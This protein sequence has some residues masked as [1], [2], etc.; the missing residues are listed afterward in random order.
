M[1]RLSGLD[2]SFLYLETPAQLHARV[3]PDRARPGARSPDG[4][5]FATMRAEIDAP[6]RATSRSSAASCARSRCGLDHPVWVDDDALRH[7][8]A[9]APAR[10][11]RRPAGTSELADLCGHLAGIPLDRSRPLWEMWVI[12]GLDDGRGRG[13]H[14]DAPRHRRRRLRREPDLPP[15]QPRARRRRRSAPARAGAARPRRPASASCSAARWCATCAQPV[16]A[17]RLL[18]PSVQRWSPAPSTA[19]AA[20]R[21][22]AAPFTAPRTSFNGTITGHRAIA[23][24]RPGPR[25]RSRR[26]RTPPART[27]NDVVLTVSRRRA[28]RATSSDRGELP[29]TSLLATVPVSVRGSR[30]ARAAPTRSRRSSPGSAPTSR[31]RSSG[32][33]TSAEQQPQR[34][35]PPQGDQRRR[36]AGLGRVRRAHAP[37]ASPCAPTPGCAWP[38]STRSC[39]TW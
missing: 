39:T 12:E 16:A 2:A 13:L 15:V 18:A 36:A 26:S 5:S 17:V 14:E 38:S 6:G 3:R 19:P 20:A 21:A 4:Y 32:S 30:S 37:S 25:R 23:L 34:Q 29:D 7:R 22:M 8:P 11:A 1:D 31:T 10:A 24:R 9:R 35:G 27:V 33:R 28:A